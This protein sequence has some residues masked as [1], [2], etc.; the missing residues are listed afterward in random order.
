MTVAT[1]RLGNV[2]TII[3]NRPEVRGA[4]DRDPARALW[5]AF[6]DF[7]ASDALVAVLATGGH[8]RLR[9]LGSETVAASLDGARPR[10]HMTARLSCRLDKTARP[11]DTPPMLG[12]ILMVALGGATGATLRYLTGLGIVRVMGHTS[13]P[14]T[15]ISV[16]ILGSFVMGA[17]VT[18]AAHRG[19]TH[20]SPLVVTG[21]LG[22]FTTFSSFSLET[23]TLLERGQPGIAAL[24]V[25]L[26]V[27]VSVAAL[28]IGILAAR[29]AFV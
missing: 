29:A 26:S 5:Q 3:H 21:L 25:L 2:L 23:V 1:A 22:G 18:V 4:M 19:L 15:I 9:G 24:Y 6:R 27:A 16:N 7:E 12:S 17:F 13:F 10:V 20:L 28:A 8:G 11:S 14:L